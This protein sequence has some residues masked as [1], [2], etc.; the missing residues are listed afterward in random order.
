VTWR[1]TIH[2]RSALAA[3]LLPVF[4]RLW[5]GYAAQSLAEL[6]DQMVR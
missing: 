5:K 6:S 4:G 1:W 2:P 3:P